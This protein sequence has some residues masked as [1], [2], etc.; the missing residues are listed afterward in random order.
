MS[1]ETFG[2]TNKKRS[3]RIASIKAGEN[4]SVMAGSLNEIDA[5]AE[6][7]GF[8][9]RAGATTIAVKRKALARQRHSIFVA[10]F[11]YSIRS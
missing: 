4:S 11:A 1:D 10:L 2:F 6:R 5:A 9:S 8:I 7:H 3:D